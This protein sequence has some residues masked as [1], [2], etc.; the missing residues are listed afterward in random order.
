MPQSDP[1][2]LKSLRLSE[3]VSKSL[4]TK[5]PP[6]H[7]PGEQFLK[8]PIP[9]Q[10]LLEAARLRGKALHIALLLWK[11][12]GCRKSRN[13]RFCLSQAKSM[14]MHLDTARRGLRQLAK[15]GLIEI[16]HRPGQGFEVSL[17]EVEPEGM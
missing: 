14:G 12:A 11:T 1:F 3:T 15:A 17:S 7:R 6:R 16:S 8:G 2:D 9:W 4:S 10:W 5:Q 13:V